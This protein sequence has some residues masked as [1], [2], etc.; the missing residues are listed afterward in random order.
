MA[1]GTGAIV[2]SAVVAGL[3]AIGVTVAIERFGGVVG[4]LIATLPTTIVPASWAMFSSAPDPAVFRDAIFF[5]PAGMLL[6]AGF[7]WLW[8]VLPQRLPNRSLGVRL[9]LMVTLTLGAWLVAAVGLVI[10]VDAARTAGLP[11]L[12]VGLGATATMLVAGVWACWHHVPAPRGARQ[13]GGGAL[14][15]RG[16]LAAGAI[17]VAGLLA[18]GGFG[19]LSGV[20]SVFP[21]IF[22]TTMVALWLAQGQAV[23][24]GAV[25]PMML[26][27]S[28]VATYAL[29]AG[30]LMP[31]LGALPGV[32]VA[33]P[34]AVVLVTVPASRWLRSRDRA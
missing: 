11:T 20:A 1:I 6:N 29:G 5:A 23:P 25:G 15:L 8:R 27:S 28:S 24:A 12:V 14:L 32:L 21:A 19:L 22:A 4:G 2:G 3:V 33:W 17:G 34:L 10:G 26:G 13:V 18:Q 16:F 30:L 31:A 9:T 7:L